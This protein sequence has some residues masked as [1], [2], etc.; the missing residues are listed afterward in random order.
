MPENPTILVVDDEEVVRIALT[1]ILD[2]YGYHVI[3]AASGHEAIRIVAGIPPGSVHLAIL[4]LMMPGIDGIETMRRLTALD[5]NTQII[6]SSGY[7]ESET[8]ERFQLS[9]KDRTTLH[10]LQ[11]PYPMAEIMRLVR[12]G[13]AGRPRRPE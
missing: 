5:P 1:D 12:S 9:E 11:K 6:I 7:D 8:Y 2:M 13:L 4:D 10:F 3:T